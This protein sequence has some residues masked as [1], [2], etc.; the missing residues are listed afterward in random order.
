MA[1][2]KDAITNSPNSRLLAMLKITIPHRHYEGVFAD[3]SGVWREL[4]HKIRY[5]KEVNIRKVRYS[6]GGSMSEKNGSLT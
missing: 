1:I 4:W 2:T 6:S 5:S 3:L